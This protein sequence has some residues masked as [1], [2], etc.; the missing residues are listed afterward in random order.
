MTRCRACILGAA[1]L[2]AGIQLVGCGSRKAAAPSS[3]GFVL[4]D[5]AAKIGLT[6]R[7]EPGGKPPR[8]ILQLMPGGA[9][10]LDFDADGWQDVLCVGQPKVALYR[11]DHGRFVDVTEKSGLGR[12]TGQWI[13]CAT[14]DFDNDGFVD[15]FIT[16]YNDTAL[17]HNNGDGTFTDI[18]DAAGARIRRWCTS[19]AF[20]DVNRDGFLDLYVGCYVRFGPGMPEFTTARGVPLSLG[21]DAYD[22]QRGVLFLNDGHGHFRDVTH[23]AGLDTGP[24]K[25]LGVAFGDPEEHG[26]DDLVLTNDQEPLDF[27]RND[28]RGRFRDVAMEN[29]TAFTCE[30][31]RQGGMGLDFGDYDGDGRLDLFVANFADEPK[32][33]YRNVGRDTYEN[34]GYPAGVS[35]STRPWVAF[36]SRFVDLDHDGELDLAIVNGHVQDWIQKVDRNNSYPQRAQLFANAGGG[37]FRE[38]SDQVG[39]DFRQPMV[40]RALAVGDFDNDGD[41]DLLVAD[42]GGPIHL[43]QNEAGNS[44]GHWLQIRLTGSRSNRMAIGARVEITAAGRRQVRAMRT[45]GSYLAAHDARIHFGLGTPRTVDEIRVRWPSGARQVLRSVPANQLLTLTEPKS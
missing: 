44:H 4:H 38:I 41:Q 26:A 32:S 40:G 1:T 36:G 23:A 11:N 43:F 17:Y 10:F 22:P 28:G 3:A 15:L 9:G 42:L 12:R 25:T 14:G 21:P 33:L 24:G 35:Q 27:Y 6:Y 31:K 5:V 30:G 37:R 8:N 39:A 18:T 29:G 34:V 13:G 45:D 7:Y 19:A 20:G 16:G 2:V